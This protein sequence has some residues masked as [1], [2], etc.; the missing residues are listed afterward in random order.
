MR[1][2]CGGFLAL[3]F[4]LWISPLPHLR[5]ASHLFPRVLV[6][7]P[8]TC[9]S[10][11]PS[12]ERGIIELSVTLPGGLVV[13]ISAPS[14]ASALA[15]QLL[16]HVA[17]FEPVSPA[18]SEFE[19]LS[20]LGA[21]S[22][23]EPAVPRPL[24]TRDQIRRSFGTCPA[25]LFGFSPRLCG[26]S[27]SGRARVERAWLCGQWAAAVQ[28]NRI[29]SPDRTEPIDLK[30]RFYA[31]LRASISQSFPSETEARIYLQSAG[32]EDFDIAA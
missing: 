12:P 3:D 5:L 17:A 22:P 23:R 10:Q 24:E 8:P 31:V 16:S 25:A 19:V 20:S 2:Y 30:S 28:S 27:L 4:L 18:P 32:V 14:S 7:L 6:F 29:H 26:S 15:T 21:P 1:A 9:M 13:R 11:G